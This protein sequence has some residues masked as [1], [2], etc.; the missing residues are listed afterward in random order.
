MYWAKLSLSL[1]YHCHKSVGCDV[2][3]FQVVDI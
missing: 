3:I 2:I 1:Y